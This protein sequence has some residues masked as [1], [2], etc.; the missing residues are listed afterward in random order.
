MSNRLA[1]ESSLYLQQHANNPVDWWPW[2]PEALAEAE[3]SGKPLLIS[4]GY[5]SCHWCHV[6]AHE[7]FED[8][9]I[10]GLMNQ[11]FVC[12]KVD[13]EERPDV[14][15]IY[16]EAVQM[17]N[18]R[19]GWPLNVFCLPDGR[20]FFGGTYFPPEDRGQGI[21]PWPQL[22]MRIGD[23]YRRSRKDLEENAD[24]ILKNMAFSNQP[25]EADEAGVSGED[26]LAAVE[27]LSQNHDEEWG[28]FGDAPKFPPSM[29]LDFLLAVRSTAACEER[30]GM[31][32]RIDRIVRNTL[33]GMAHGGIYDQLGGGFARYS[34]D[35][36]W[37]IPHFEKMLYDNALLLDCYTKGWLRYRDPL[38][39]AVVEETVDWLQ[40][41]MLSPEGFFHA[42]IDADSE[43]HE[44]KFYVWR[45]E[46]I[47]EILGDEDGHTFCE[48]YA[49]SEKGNFEH[50]S[51]N[52][53]WTG[54]DLADREQLRP[55]REKLLAARAQRVAP[56]TDTKIILSWNA[57]MIRALA[58]A[59]F[60]FGRKDWL[61]LAQKAA[62]GLSQKVQDTDGRLHSVY[63]PE[64]ATGNGNLE[65]YAFFIEA[66]LALASKA[67][68]IEPGLS[69]RYREQA[70]KLMET[71][72]RLF[73][74][75]HAVGFFFT[76]SDQQDLVT[77]KKNWYD[78][79]SPAGNSSLL[80]SLSAL[81]ALTGKQH[82]ADELA[83]MRKAYPGLSRRVPN[84]VAH[85]LSALTWDMLGIATL[86]APNPD[87]LEVARDSLTAKPW[88]KTFFSIAENGTPGDGFLLCVGTQCLPP[89]HDLNELTSYYG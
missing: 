78:N 3:K 44:G 80:H 24:N 27:T 25:P 55:L 76:A 33:N 72:F 18:Q 65:D 58:E 59:G 14:D 38:Y 56:A 62:E 17:I 75:E 19:G 42:S 43:G 10:A 4:I 61:A 60:A 54:A 70:D 6:M 69:V 83:D 12:I 57:L 79:A 34:V 84:A 8:E 36:Y 86:K 16:M 32:D 88:R 5:S 21:I 23:H 1:Q 11:N 74:D 71:A 30:P 51:S 45:P 15:Q 77:R 82:Y 28:G 85:A 31:A 2:C 87:G 29:I 50:G 81:Y 67:D 47:R 26:L 20:P 37:V 40:R 53:V 7:C 73:R 68:W 41:E 66:L 39:R 89:I 46:E 22:L 35:K 13:R 49:I 48:A 63:Y 9:Y 52:P 64:G